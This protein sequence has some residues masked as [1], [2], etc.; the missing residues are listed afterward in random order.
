MGIS[1]I[2]NMEKCILEVKEIKLDKGIFDLVADCTYVLLC[3]GTKP[4]REESVYHNINILKPTRLIKL[5]YNSG[6]KNCECSNTAQEDMGKAQLYIFEDALKNNYTRILFLEDDFLVQKKLDRD[7]VYSIN[8]FIHDQDPSVYGLG[9]FSIPTLDT[10]FSPHQRVVGNL[11][12]MAHA[13]MYNAQYMRKVRQYYKKHDTIIMHDILTGRIDNIRNYKYYKP[14]IYQ[15]FPS[16]DNQRECWQ[17][18]FP[19]T[20]LIRFIMWSIKLL[21]LDTQVQ[22]GYNIIYCLPYLLYMCI[23]IIIIKIIMIYKKKK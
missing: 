6:Y 23:A 15:T 1:I 20:V 4:P 5:V 21:R 10:M 17:S 12:G 14:L 22:P 8:K 7:D 18:M 3:C 11:L 9:N 13:V 2:I 19:S 16:T